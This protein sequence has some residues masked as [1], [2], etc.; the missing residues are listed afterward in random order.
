MRFRVLPVLGLLAFGG[1]A[2]ASSPLHTE[3]PA[4]ITIL[5]DAFGGAPG[6]TQDWGFA[7]L[8]EYQGHRILFDTGDNAAIFEHN[9]RALHVD[10]RHLDFAVISHRHGDHIAGLSYL[11]RVNPHGRATLVH[12]ALRRTGVAA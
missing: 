4:R 11:L 1:P 6:L 8:V 5:Y 2:Y 10:L 9:V 7:A 12:H 3:A